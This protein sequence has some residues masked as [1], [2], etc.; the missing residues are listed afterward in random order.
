VYEDVATKG[1]QALLR[2]RANTIAD[3]EALYHIHFRPREPQ[4]KYVYYIGEWYKSI[5]TYDKVAIYKDFEKKSTTTK[6]NFKESD[7][8]KFSICK[9]EITVS[10]GDKKEKHVDNENDKGGEVQEVIEKKLQKI[11]QIENNMNDIVEMNKEK[12]SAA[13][14]PKDKIEESINNEGGKVQKDI[15]KE[16]QEIKK[17]ND[18]LNDMIKKLLNKLNQES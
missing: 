8:D 10:E 18:N 6:H 3:H 17:M 13:A 14:A 11:K 2:Y 5:R 7:Y 12:S 9:Y 15:E 1:R 16:I 4:P